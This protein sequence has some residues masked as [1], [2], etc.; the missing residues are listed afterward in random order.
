[1]HCLFFFSSLKGWN[2]Q[3]ETPCRPPT[4][5]AGIPLLTP[6]LLPPGVP[7]P[8]KP[9]LGVELGSRCWHCRMGCGHSQEH[10]GRCV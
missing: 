4:Q 8:R 2:Q 6:P 9:E 10:V 3:L 5:V 1:M 7:I